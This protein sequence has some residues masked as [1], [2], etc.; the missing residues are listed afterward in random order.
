[1]NVGSHGDIAEVVNNSA[2]ANVAQLVG[3][4]EGEVLVPFYDWAAMFAPHFR[5]L[6]NKVLP[7]LPF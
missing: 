4:Q 2:N 5:K 6:K 7:P 3:T 1:M